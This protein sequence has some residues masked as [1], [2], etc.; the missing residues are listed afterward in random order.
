MNSRTNKM[1]K[2]MPTKAAVR[3][4]TPGSRVPHGRSVLGGCG[5]GQA[6]SGVRVEAEEVRFG[7]GVGAGA[8]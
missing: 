8:G 2:I 6:C 3:S 7:A 4:K 5:G 1:V